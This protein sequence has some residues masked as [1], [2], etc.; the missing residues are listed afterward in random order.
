M[1]QFALDPVFQ[2]WFRSRP[3]RIQNMVLENPPWDFYTMNNDGDVYQVYSYLEDGTVTVIR[4]SRTTSGDEWTPLWR[5]FGVD[6][7]S[8]VKQEGWRYEPEQDKS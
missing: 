1:E 7:A 4:Y 2:E 5:V 8:L 6:P 3:Q